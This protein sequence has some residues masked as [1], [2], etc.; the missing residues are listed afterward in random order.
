[1][2][3]YM[4]KKS[5]YDLA[6]MEIESPFIEEIIRIIV[7]HKFKQPQMESYDESGSPVDDVR[8]YR[9]CMALTTNLDEFYYLA[10]PSTLKGPVNQWFD[11]LRPMSIVSFD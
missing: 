7:P 3:R 5:T 8:A 9:P 2:T 10:F 1:M 6:S 4:D 11:T